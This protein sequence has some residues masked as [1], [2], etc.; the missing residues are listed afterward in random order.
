MKS[1]ITIKCVCGKDIELEVYGGQYPNEY[2]R[3]CECV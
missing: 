2:R 3:R 1:K